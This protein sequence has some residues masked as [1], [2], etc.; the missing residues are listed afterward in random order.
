MFRFFSAGTDLGRAARLMV[1]VDYSQ[2][3][4]LVAVRGTRDEVVGAGDL[5]RWRAGRGGDR[6]RDRGRGCRDVGL[7]T[8][9]LAHLAEVAQ[10]NGISIFTAEVH[11]AEPPDDRG[12]PRER[13]P[14]RDVVPC[15]AR[16]TS[17]CR[18]PFSD[19]A[20]LAI[21]R[22]ATG[23]PRSAAVR[24]FLEPRSGRG[25]RR[26]AHARHDRGG[27]VPQPPLALVPG[28]RVPVNNR[29]RGPVGA[30]LPERGGR[31]PTRSTSR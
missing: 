6:V 9:L 5:P 8:L 27:D 13:L 26:V 17:S 31:P 28:G 29:R 25:N 15:P 7:G 16:S 10:E 4:G 2:R 14:G 21:S 3:Y 23:S 24:R 12:L 19:E 22:T 11:A 30:R 1:D 18:R 20:R